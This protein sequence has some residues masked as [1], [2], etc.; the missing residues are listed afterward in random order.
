MSHPCIYRANGKISSWGRE[1]SPESARFEAHI[2]SGV[3]AQVRHCREIPC[4]ACR[5]PTPLAALRGEPQRWVC[6]SCFTPAPEEDTM[7][8]P[9][10]QHVVEEAR[11]MIERGCSDKEIAAALPISRATASRIRQRDPEVDAPTADKAERVADALKEGKTYREISSDLGVSQTTI[12]EVKRAQV[13][14]SSV[15]PP[16]K[17]PTAEEEIARLRRMVDLAKD[18]WRAAREVAFW[19]EQVSDAEHNLRR[20]KEEAAAARDHLRDVERAIGEVEP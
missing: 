6:P 18:A 11:A 3:D 14:T 15:P 2:R 13:A 12:A 10:P 16:E 5:T 1:R 17:T 8:R 19:T 4:A 20:V 7:P 9:T